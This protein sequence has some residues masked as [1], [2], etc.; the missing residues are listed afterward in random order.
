MYIP[1]KK[2]NAPDARY[3]E[4][5]R[6]YIEWRVKLAWSALQYDAECAMRNVQYAL[7]ALQAILA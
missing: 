3:E 5:H 7:M 6:K 1:H 4:A 2:Y